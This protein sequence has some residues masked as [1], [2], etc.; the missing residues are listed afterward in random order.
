MAF[1]RQRNLCEKPG[2]EFS[3]GLQTMGSVSTPSKGTNLDAGGVLVGKGNGTATDLPGH[4]LTVEY[5]TV[6]EP[7]V[8]LT[9]PEQTV[10][11]NFAKKM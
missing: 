1:K 3:M 4:A 10:L 2:D 6:R 9:V 5:G 7:I 11:T 8:Y